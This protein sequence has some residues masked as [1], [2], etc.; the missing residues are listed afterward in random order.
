MAYRQMAP[1]KTIYPRTAP[2]PMQSYSA[3]FTAPGGQTTLA[4]WGL[5][6][7]A[8]L[9]R[10]LD[11]NLD[12]VSVRQCSGGKVSA[13]PPTSQSTAPARGRLYLVRGQAGR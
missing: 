12:N 5:K 11:F 9:N 7:W 1:L 3:R 6:K 10:E 13:G 8:T 4:I 2:G